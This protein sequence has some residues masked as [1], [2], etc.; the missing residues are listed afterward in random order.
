V[1]TGLA[2]VDHIVVL[3]LENRS[4]DHM[5]G[6]RYRDSAKVSA[7]GD[8]FDGLTGTESCPGADGTPVQVFP[9]TPTTANAYFLAGRRPR[10]GVFGH[11]RPVV[12]R[13]IAARGCCCVDAGIRHRLR[14]NLAHP[15]ATRLVCSPG[16]HRRHD[17]GLLYTGNAAGAQRTGMRLHGL[18]RWFGSAPTETMPNRA[19]ACAGTSQGHLD[20]VTK[21]FTVPSIFG[22]CG[23]HGVA[24]KTYGYNR[25]PL[26]RL[27]FPDTAQAPAANIGLFTDF[28]NDAAA[29]RLPAF[30]FLEPPDD[31]IGEY[32][33][34]SL[35]TA[36][37]CLPS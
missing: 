17:H 13:R 6:F 31:T 35:A 12:R 9:I 18:R 11:Q 22:L 37:V 23:Q 30:A 28:Q 1:V 15:H 27:N 16:H 2:S 4:F 25:K 20:D 8:P 34:T 26:T 36:P 7:R 33:S 3:M 10:R 29:A 24:W 14:A 32:G 21:S 5:L 19:F